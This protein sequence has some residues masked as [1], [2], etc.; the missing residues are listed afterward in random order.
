MPASP[1]SNTL[2]K[3]C[4]T[5]V[6]EHSKQSCYKCFILLKPKCAYSPYTKQENLGGRDQEIVL[7]TPGLLGVSWVASIY[8]PLRGRINSWRRGS[9]AAWEAPVASLSEHGL[10]GGSWREKRADRTEVCRAEGVCSPT[11]PWVTHVWV[12]WT[13][14]YWNWFP[15]IYENYIK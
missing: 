13:F 9:S 14:R 7:I 8:L 2:F 1:L 15:N 5:E 12:N 11:K 4:K 10:E 3:L 6:C